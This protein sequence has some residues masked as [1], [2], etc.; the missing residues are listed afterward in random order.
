MNNNLQLNCKKSESGLF[1]EFNNNE[2]DQK[3]PTVREFSRAVKQWKKDNKVRSLKKYA[4][5]GDNNLLPFYQIA[6]IGKYLCRREIEVEQIF[7]KDWNTKVLIPVLAHYEKKLYRGL[8]AH[9]GDT[10]RKYW[11]QQIPFRCEGS[12]L[13][14][15]EPL[16]RAKRKNVEKLHPIN[17][18]LFSGFYEIQGLNLIKLNSNRFN[19][20]KLQDPKKYNGLHYLPFSSIDEY[21]LSTGGIKENFDQALS[22]FFSDLGSGK[23]VKFDDSPSNIIF[24]QVNYDNHSFACMY[25]CFTKKIDQSNHLQNI[26]IIA[27]DFLPDADINS[28]TLCVSQ[29]FKKIIETLFQGE[30]FFHI[31]YYG[32]IQDEADDTNCPLYS[33]NTI[34]ALVKLSTD[35]K[36]HEFLFDQNSSFE[37]L[38]KQLQQTLP[39]YFTEKSGEVHLKTSEERM[40][41]NTKDRWLMGNLAVEGFMQGEITCFQEYC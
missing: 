19:Q 22:H 3:T 26:V 12:L 15:D 9:Q 25:I 33:F 16:A 36:F 29:K 18:F 13:Q 41:I 20:L 6:A 2:N 28:K 30:N 8:S 32:G 24:H 17:S 7:V 39:Q 4:A 35:N 37:K 34:N 5:N 23:L 11:A 38:K 21:F 40:I 31:V 10:K 1:F 14:N 27:F